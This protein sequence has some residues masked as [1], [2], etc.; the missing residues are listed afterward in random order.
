MSGAQSVSLPMYATAR[1]RPLWQ[2]FWEEIRAHLPGPTPQALGWPDDLPNH[3]RQPDL[4]LSQTCGLPLRQGL[5]RH[6]S[7]LGAFDFAL[8]GCPPGHYASVIAVRE[9]DPADTLSALA[10]APFAMNAA[11]SQSGHAALCA[12]FAAIGLTPGRPVTS[13]SHRASMVAVAEGRARLAAIDAET[14]RI[15]GEEGAQAGLRPLMRT[16]PTPGLPLITAR[17]RAP[18]PLRAAL[19]A[20]AATAPKALHIAGFVAWD[21]AAYGLPRP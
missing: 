5:S 12:A 3:W 2:A 16:A 13:G 4:L 11:D 17:G 8:P 18:G 14:W 21:Q 7:V 9:D 19:A 1:T 15:A 20:A 6:V 10:G